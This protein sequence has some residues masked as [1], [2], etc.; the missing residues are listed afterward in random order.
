M[1]IE[2]TYPKCKS[3]WKYVA[4]LELFKSIKPPLPDKYDAADQRGGGIILHETDEIDFYPW[5]K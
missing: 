2:S 5:N 3:A 4:I 1:V